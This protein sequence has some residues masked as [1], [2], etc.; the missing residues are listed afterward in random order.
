[1]APEI[2]ADALN[3]LSHRIIEAAIEIHSK[4]GP[5]LLE[6]IYRAC[7]I[8]ELRS[9]GL[10]VLAE[11][12]IPIQYKDLVL[13]GCY[14]LDLLVADQVV[15]EL[16]WVETLVPVHHAQLLSYL[17]LTHK[18]LGLLINFNVPYLVRGVRRIANHPCFSSSADSEI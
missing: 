3:R 8:Y 17:R 10:T 16:K 13:D 15:V 9:A 14:R 11:Q 12:L 1:V 4:I 2:D 18:P 5:G 6:S 7:M